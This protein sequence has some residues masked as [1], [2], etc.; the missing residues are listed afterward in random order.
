MLSTI[1]LFAY[2]DYADAGVDHADADVD[3][4]L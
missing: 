4:M 3:R 2:V 1:I